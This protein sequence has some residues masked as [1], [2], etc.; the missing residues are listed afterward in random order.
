M[1]LALEHAVRAS[2]P[3]A[4]RVTLHSAGLLPEAYHPQIPPKPCCNCDSLLVC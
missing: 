3:I 1:Y 4:L 2:R